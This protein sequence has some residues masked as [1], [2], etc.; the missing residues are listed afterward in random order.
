MKAPRPTTETKKNFHKEKV[1]KLV[2]H[3]INLQGHTPGVRWCPSS[4]LSHLR[5]HMPSLHCSHHHQTLLVQYQKLTTWPSKIAQAIRFSPNISQLSKKHHAN[6]Y[7]PVMECHGK[8]EFCELQLSSSTKFLQPFECLIRS[9]AS[10]PETRA[11][12][13]DEGGRDSDASPT[14]PTLIWSTCSAKGIPTLQKMGS[15]F[16]TPYVAPGN[17]MDLSYLQ[18]PTSS[19]CRSAKLPWCKGVPMHQG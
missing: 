10:R 12:E 14:S 8:V 19:A 11:I 17:F 9:E 13:F 4:Y 18:N 6:H 1:K 3:L 15:L 7:Q 2:G 5:S 16:Y